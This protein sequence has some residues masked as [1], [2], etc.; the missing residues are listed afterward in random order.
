[1]SSRITLTEK[2]ERSLRDM[3]P[4]DQQDVIGAFVML[5]FDIEAR[6]LGKFEIFLPRADGRST[7]GYETDA[8]W[9][10]FVEM[11]DGDIEI[12][13]VAYRDPFRPPGPHPYGRG[14]SDGG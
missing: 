4:D 6:D 1:M 11:D 14:G 2:A 9:I 12:E 13:H 5:A 7:W 8:L 3:R 10:A